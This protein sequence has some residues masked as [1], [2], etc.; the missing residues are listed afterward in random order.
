MSLLFLLM[1]VFIFFF[2]IKSQCTWFSACLWLGIQGKD[3][4]VTIL[5]WPF[6]V[7]SL[8]HTCAIIML[9]NQHLDMPHLWGGLWTI[10]ERN[11]PFVD[12]EKILDLWIQLIK[13]GG[14]YSVYIYIYIYIYMYDELAASPLLSSPPHSLFVALH[15]APDGSGCVREEGV[16]ETARA[17]GVCWGAP[18]PNRASSPPLFKWQARCYS[19]DRSLPRPWRENGGNSVLPETWAAG[20]SVRTNRTR[21]TAVGPGCQADQSRRAPWAK[22]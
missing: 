17:G 14:I 8:R 6:I 11:R 20:P 1:T 21:D 5:E 19:R 2:S 4:L 13:N 10:F 12:I 3:H 15:Q 9:S 7:A 22:R 16:A 18:E